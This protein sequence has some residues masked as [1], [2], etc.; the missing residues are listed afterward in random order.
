MADKRVWVKWMELRVNGDVDAIK[1]PT[2]YIPK[3]EDLKKLFKDVLKKDY[4][5]SQYDEQFASR[6][7]E[8]LDKIE[9]IKEIYKTK[10]KNTPNE[11]FNILDE[12]KKRLEEAEEV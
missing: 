10:I 3:S 12:Q 5:Q 7:K 8:N 11:L 9:R 6:P 1:T 2:G 4:S